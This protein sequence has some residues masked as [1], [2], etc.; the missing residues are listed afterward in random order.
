MIIPE[1]QIP[2]TAKPPDRVSTLIAKLEG[3]P[4]E[5]NEFLSNVFSHSP[6]LLDCASKEPEFLSSLLNE[7]FDQ[8]AAKLIAEAQVLGVTAE[9]EGDVMTALRIA[10]RRVALLCALADLGGW[11]IDAQVTRTLSNFADA[12]LVACLDHIL[13]SQHHA[14]KLVLHDTANPSKDSGLIVLG[15]GKLGGYELNYSSDIDLIVFY[16][17]QAKLT[18]NSDDPISVLNRM[19][20]QLIKMMQERTADGY[21][22]RMDLRLRPDPSSTPLIISVD[23]AF[24]YYEGQG[25]NWERSAMIKARASAGDFVAASSFLKYL[26]PFVWRKYL[27]FAAIGDIQSIKRQIHAHKGHGEIAVLGHNI[28]LGRGGIREIEF[29]AQ[30]QQLIAG[31]RN[32]ELRG[33]E[34]TDALLALA[35]HHWISEQTAYELIEAYW[36]LRSVE[37]RLQMLRDE[38]THT[39]PDTQEELEVIANLCGEA[40][41]ARFQEHLTQTLRMVETHY[42]SL[43][44][45]E[46]ELTILDGNLVFTGDDFDPETVSTIKSLGYSRPEDIINTIKGWHMARAPALRASKARELLT[47]L[48]PFLLETFSRTGK[49]DEVL[50]S[51][52]KFVS[53]LPAGVQLF[54]LLKNNSEL[55]ILLIRILD[56]APRLAE[57]IARRPHIFDH[58]I[59]PVSDNIGITRATLDPELEAL[60]QRSSDYEGFLDDIRRFASEIRFQIGSRFFSGQVSSR[61][62]A[63]EYS[64]LAEAVICVTFTRVLEEFSRAHGHVEGAEFCILAMGRLGSRELTATSDLDL[65]FLYDLPEHPLEASNGAKPLDTS[66]YF[67]R[68]VQRFIS[69]M[70]APTAEGVLY[71]LDFRLRPSGNA[72]PLA[73]S[74]EGFFKYQQQDAWVWEGQALTRARPVLGDDDLSAKVTDGISSVLNEVDTRYSIDAEIVKMRELIQSEKGSKDPWD[75]KS[76]SGG[77]IDIEFIAQWAALKNP[78]QSKGLTGTREILSCAGLNGLPVEDAG[79]LIKAF[80][81]YSEVLHLERIC[82]G[83]FETSQEMPTGFLT[84]LCERI[85]QPTKA[86]CTAHLKDSQAA[87]RQIFKKLLVR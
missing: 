43:F 23:A 73:T 10:K 35:R 55:M 34:T 71:P 16:D 4:P 21:V 79:V 3:L 30:T 52:D 59:D 57:L 45:A 2:N 77:F 67:I 13:L 41:V 63:S 20:K 7:G 5:L 72:G 25:Q 50:F 84:I 26:L 12:A 27:D 87:V 82:L 49:P 33:R 15:M 6:F 81:L 58:M 8:P 80:D 14:G 56:A 64:A 39:L 78:H 40:D 46:P 31:G 18:I 69:A 47:E 11:W 42:A 83:G 9:S 38:Q 29:F 32:P 22:F 17:D 86:A 1:K 44:E 54:S 75:V 37:H 68:L 74:V 53:G 60:V 65:I 51:F 61:Q 48:V 76:V 85:D 24:N 62:A 19:G 28:K 66:L 36:V 70:T